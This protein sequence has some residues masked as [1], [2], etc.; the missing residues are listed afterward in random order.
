MQD[1]L[2]KV[3]HVALNLTHKGFAKLQLKVNYAIRSSAPVIFSPPATSARAPLICQPGALPALP[4]S[5]A[6][7]FLSYWLL[8]PRRVSTCTQALLKA[9][10]PHGKV[11]QT[12]WGESLALSPC[13]HSL[14]GPRAFCCPPLEL[15]SGLVDDRDE[16]PRF[17]SRQRPTLH[18]VRF[19][20]YG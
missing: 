3:M 18:S 2:A 16:V 14:D 13:C 10:P 7:P 19:L 4:V 8:V 12:Q 9:R 17:P 20:G 5:F 6:S 1:R 11:Q 15:G